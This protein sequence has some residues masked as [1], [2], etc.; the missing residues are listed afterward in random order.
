MILTKEIKIELTNFNYHNYERLGYDTK[1]KSFIFLDINDLGKGSMQRINVK[2]DICSNEKYIGYRKYLKN[3][4]KYNIYCCS[5]KCAMFKNKLTNLDL[6]GIE[7]QCQSKEVVDKILKT[8]IN[9]GLISESFS[10][11]SGYTKLVSKL[12]KRVKK[13]LFNTWDGYDYY[14]REYINDNLNL[15]CNDRLYPSIDHKISVLY[16]YLN[17]IDYKIISD[18]SNLCI[19]KRTNNSSKGF[20]CEE[21]F[22]NKK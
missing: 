10:D 19:T 2:C 9:K 16:G 22:K 15:N 20:K 6:Y 12:T 5:N 3:I 21:Q 1:E 11:L 13:D 7:H 8:K 4:S 17:N 18:I 14:D